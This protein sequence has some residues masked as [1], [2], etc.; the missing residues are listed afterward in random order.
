MARRNSGRLDSPEAERDESSPAPLLVN[1][2]NENMFSFV[3]PTEFVDLPS[4]GLL[5]GPDH[6][7]YEVDTIEIKHMT[8]K[9]EDLLTSEALIRKGL[10][11]D[12]LLQSVIVNSDIKINDLLVGDKNALLIASRITGYGP[13][14]TT[15]VTCP[16]C[17]TQKEEEINLHELTLKDTSLPDNATLTEN[18]TYLLVFDEYDLTVEIRLLKGSDETMVAQRRQKRR[19]LKLPEN[20]IT[21][22]LE[23]IITSVNDEKS[24][25]LIKK[26]CEVVPASVSRKIRSAYEQAMPDLDL[27]YEFECDGCSH[28]GKVGM[29]LTAEF[30]W[31]NS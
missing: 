22:Q 17:N 18:G 13:H 14:Y 24:S 25:S 11:L 21:D 15:I 26:F 8:A 10:A 2:S 29:P 9:E 5:Y 4:K 6:P 16:S 28:V 30:F 20:N 7:L 19:K 1:D 27:T 31:P 23:A 3:T 12:R